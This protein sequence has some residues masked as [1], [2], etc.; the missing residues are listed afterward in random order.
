MPWLPQVRHRFP[1]SR[2]GAWRWK[3]RVVKGAVQI[4]PTDAG[5]SGSTS[6]TAPA[7]PAQWVLAFT[8]NEENVA[9]LRKVVEPIIDRVGAPKVVPPLHKPGEAQSQSKGSESNTQLDERKT[10]RRLEFFGIWKLESRSERRQSGPS[11][12]P[13]RAGSPPEVQAVPKYRLPPPMSR[14][15]PQPPE[16][17]AQRAHEVLQQELTAAQGD[18][19]PVASD[20]ADEGA[21]LVI[22]EVVVTQSARDRSSYS[23][24]RIL[25]P[26][27]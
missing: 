16:L 20:T 9:A 1:F 25:P 23:V 24:F 3:S 7:A 21:P 18:W 4:F 22:L 26:S 5:P 12:L 19:A 14:A 6:T 8:G 11:P 15:P 10:G 27:T 17:V 2:C 13:M